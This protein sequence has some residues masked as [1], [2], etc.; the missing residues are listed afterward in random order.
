MHVTGVLWNSIHNLSKFR[1]E[2]PAGCSYVL[3]A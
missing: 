1:K 3:R 2:T